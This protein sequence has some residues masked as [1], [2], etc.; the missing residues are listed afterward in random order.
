METTVVPSASEAGERV[1]MA[2]VEDEAQPLSLH[3][4]PCTAYVDRF[5]HGVLGWSIWFRTRPRTT[6]RCSQA[7]E[8]RVV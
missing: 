4:R 5:S 6:V 1:L 2:P 8:Q 7:F 3:W